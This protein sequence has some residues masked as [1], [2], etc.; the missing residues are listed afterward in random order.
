MESDDNA[1]PKP[2][3]VRVRS[4]RTGT[5]GWALRCVDQ[6]EKTGIEFIS[7]AVCFDNGAGGGLYRPEDITVIGQ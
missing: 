5:K 7:Y 6:C 1:T 3:I 2:D 4:R